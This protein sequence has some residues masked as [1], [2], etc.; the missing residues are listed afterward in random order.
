MVLYNKVTIGFDPYFVEF[1]KNLGMSQ[2]CEKHIHNHY[3]TYSHSNELLSTAQ[4]SSQ[5]LSQLIP[6]I[7]YE[8]GKSCWTHFTSG[9]TGAHKDYEIEPR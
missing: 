7:T 9:K 6:M 3:K 8:V 5:T 1:K 4:R 2:E